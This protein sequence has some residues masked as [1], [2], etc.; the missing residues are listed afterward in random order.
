MDKIPILKDKTPGKY[1]Y[2]AVYLALDK[3]GGILDKWTK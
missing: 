1:I 3:I 2:F